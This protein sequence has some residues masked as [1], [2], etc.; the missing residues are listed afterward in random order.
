MGIYK[1]LT[2][3]LF[4]QDLAK[5]YENGIDWE[6]VAMKLNTNRTPFDCFHRYQERF[7][8]HRKFGWTNEDNTYL[9]KLIKN[10]GDHFSD[11]DWEE[12][13]LHFPG[14]SKAQIYA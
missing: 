8:D 1:L 3:L 14:R 13:R 5:E 2:C 7:G 9:L 6:D 11:V 12:I 10:Y 4:L